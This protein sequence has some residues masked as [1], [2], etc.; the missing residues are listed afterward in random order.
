VAE[1][2]GR[3]PQGSGSAAIVDAKERIERKKELTFL[4]DRSKINSSKILSSAP[5]SLG[6]FFILTFRGGKRR[7]EVEFDLAWFS[8]DTSCSSI[9][10]LFISFLIGPLFWGLF[11]RELLL[12]GPSACGI[13]DERPQGEE[14]K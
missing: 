6:A 3:S 2:C 9:S 12:T 8:L 10:F 14:K 11:F 7:M 1:L 4:P 5:S 13:M